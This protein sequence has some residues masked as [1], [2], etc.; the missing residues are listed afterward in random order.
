MNKEKEKKPKI[1]IGDE[2]DGEIEGWV[3]I[4]K[5]EEDDKVAEKGYD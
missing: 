5:E 3:G 4:D 2:D 1:H